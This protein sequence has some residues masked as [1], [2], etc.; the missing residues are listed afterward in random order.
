M[1]L[2]LRAALAGVAA[3]PLAAA[4]SAAAVATAAAAAGSVAYVRSWHPPE[5]AAAVVVAAPAAGPAPRHR[6]GKKGAEAPAD[7]NKTGAAAQ[8]AG[9]GGGGGAPG[10]ARAAAAPGPSAAEGEGAPGATPSF[11]LPRVAVEAMCGAVGEIAQV[12]VLY[13]LETLKVRCQSEGRPVRGV[14]AAMVAAA[15]EAGTGPGGA[16]VGAGLRSRRVLAALYSGFGSAAALSVV[17]GALHYASFCASKRMALAEADGGPAAAAAAAA[18]ADK[19]KAAGG[20]KRRRGRQEGEAAAAAAAAPSSA[21]DGGGHG[22]GNA[23]ANLTAASVGALVTALVESPAELFRHRAQAGMLH[24]HGGGGGGPGLAGGGGSVWRAMREAV[25]LG[26]PGALFYGFGAYLM[27]SVPYDVAEL[28][29]YGSL[30]DWV[31]GRRRALAAK[32][33]AAAAKGGGGGGGKASE[34]RRTGLVAAAAAPAPL[35]FADAREG[36]FPGSGGRET[37]PRRRRRGRAAASAA[38]A[39]EEQREDEERGGDPRALL[40]RGGDPRALLE[41]GG[42]PRALL[43]RGGDPRALLERGGDPRA[44]LERRLAAWADAVVASAPA[45]ALDLAAGAAAGTAAVCISMPLDVIKTYV[46]THPEEAARAAEKVL[47]AFPAYV[48][49]NG[50]AKFAAVGAELVSRGGGGALLAGLAPRLAQQVPSAM[51]CWLVLER[52]RAALEPYTAK[53]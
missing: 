36:G 10:E 20:R 26:G 5:T 42:D 13:P 28:G 12:G 9:G 41:R 14:F 21:H 8:E 18:A 37:Q 15:G 45:E 51:L 1:S 48:R 46:Q 44:P 53:A 49:K 38:A 52:C 29:V 40:E 7:S 6:R 32:E 47:A 50:V 4:R 19:G 16:A 22:G 33:A 27:E 11:T 2:P 34:R 30:R 43:E 31:D 25:R 17:V 3:S 35:A 23:G 39:A 24:Q